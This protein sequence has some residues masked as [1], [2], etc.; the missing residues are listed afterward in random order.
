MN[1]TSKACPFCA[2]TVPASARICPRCRQWLSYR[3]LRHPVVSSLVFGLPALLCF[4]IFCYVMDQF[5]TRFTNPPPYYF[6]HPGAIRVLE[7]RINWVETK[8]GTRIY[9]TGLITNQSLLPWKDLEFDCRFFNS[10]GVMIDACDGRSSFTIQPA[11]EAAFRVIVKP[12][13]SATDYKTHRI[14]VS[15]ARTIKS[16]F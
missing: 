2:E 5:A 15:T 16:A 14:T 6:E 12:A 1:P 10:E 7:S 9:A 4:L 3:S 13:Q 8:D 11:T